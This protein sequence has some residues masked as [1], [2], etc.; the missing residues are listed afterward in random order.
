[1]LEKEYYV[2]NQLC[3]PRALIQIIL[4]YQREICELEDEELIEKMQSYQQF[5]KTTG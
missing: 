3:I 5:K 1:M 4:E 2:S